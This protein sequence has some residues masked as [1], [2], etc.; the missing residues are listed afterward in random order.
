MAELDI[1]KFRNVQRDNFLAPQ[2]A[3]LQDIRLVDRTDASL[4]GARQ[5]ES[6]SR[7]AANLVRRVLLGVEAAALPIGERFDAARFS[8]ID[9]AGQLT[10]DDEVDILEHT[11]LERRRLGQ[12]RSGS[13]GPRVGVKNAL[14]APTQ[15]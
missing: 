11:G 1:G 13:N 10:D 4:S 12:S 8:E 14:A 6:G 7:H 15:P 9:A 5:F 2:R 3:G